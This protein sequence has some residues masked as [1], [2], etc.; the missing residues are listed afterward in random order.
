M[1]KLKRALAR[2]NMEKQ[3]FG[4]FNKKHSDGRSYFAKHWREFV[5]VK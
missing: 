3:G 2:R 5:V 4:R 1:R